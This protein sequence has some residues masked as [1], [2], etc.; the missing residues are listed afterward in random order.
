MLREQAVRLVDGFTEEVLVFRRLILSGLL[1][2]VFAFAAIP[3][4]ALADGAVPEGL[5]PGIQAQAHALMDEMTEH[6]ADMNLSPDQV[7]MMM[8][9]M[10]MLA[11]EL[12]PG[13]YLNLLRLMV[14]MD[15]ESMME[16]HALLHNG[17]VASVPPGSL[18]AAAQKLVRR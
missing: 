4:G 3:G 10:E 17:D 16:L 14:Q 2:F 8:A 9:D 6:M 13:V 5:P 7:Q 1:V 15:E 18:V 11:A 12:P